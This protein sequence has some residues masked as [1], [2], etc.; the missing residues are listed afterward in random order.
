MVLIKCIYAFK[1]MNIA[2]FFSKHQ[3]GDCQYCKKWINSNRKQHAGE[4]PMNF[5]E[6]GMRSHGCQGKKE[7]GERTG[8]VLLGPSLIK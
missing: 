6:V 7:L 3:K 8:D 2:I 5:L 1:A 4:Q